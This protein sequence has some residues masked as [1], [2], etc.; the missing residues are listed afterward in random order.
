MG[1]GAKALREKLAELPDDVERSLIRTL[2]ALQDAVAHLASA[3]SVAELHRQAEEL[4]LRAR[5]RLA[6]G[7]QEGWAYPVLRLS[8]GGVEVSRA[9]QQARALDPNAGAAAVAAPQEGAAVLGG[10]PTSKARPTPPLVAWEGGLRTK[11]DF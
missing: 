1:E 3:E 4:Q 9:V 7:Q 8:V 5:A 6:D 2:N 10:N 11:K